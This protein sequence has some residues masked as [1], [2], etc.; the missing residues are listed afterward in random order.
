[1]MQPIQQ[2]FQFDGEPLRFE[3]KAPEKGSVILPG[4]FFP[5]CRYC[6]KPEMNCDCVGTFEPLRADLVIRRS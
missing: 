2:C 5:I 1:M 3:S 4:G 6:Y